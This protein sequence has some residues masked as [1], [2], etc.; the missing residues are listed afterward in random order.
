MVNLHGGAFLTGG[1][2]TYADPSPLVTKGVI[3]VNVN[4]PARRHGLPGA[5][6]AGAD[7]AAAGN[8]GIMDQQAA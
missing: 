5:S 6:G 1:A 3:V 8:Y 4:L 2:V 7:K